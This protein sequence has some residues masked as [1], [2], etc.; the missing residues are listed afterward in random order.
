MGNSNQFAKWNVNSGVE[1]S[2]RIKSL[3][4]LESGLTVAWVEASREKLEG[5]DAAAGFRSAHAGSPD[6]RGPP[7]G[8]GGAH[9]HVPPPA[10][11]PV[12]PDRQSA[13]PGSPAGPGPAGLAHPDVGPH[14]L[15]PAAAP[16]RVLSL[17]ARGMPD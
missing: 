7:G 11:R 3:W 14:L 15:G 2:L 10:R 6:S 4:W 12:L 1:E 5:R 8:H 16:A 17:A 9:R 13:L